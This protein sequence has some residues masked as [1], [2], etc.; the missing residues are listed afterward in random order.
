MSYGAKPL[1]RCHE[2]NFLDI[3]WFEAHLVEG[4]E[5]P[6]VR[7]YSVCANVFLNLD[8]KTRLDYSSEGVVV[9]SQYVG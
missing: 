7:P 8:L 1:L 3:F 4:K 2:L 9:V 6:H 5:S